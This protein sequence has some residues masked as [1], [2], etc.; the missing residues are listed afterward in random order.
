ML[1]GR[2]WSR[3]RGGSV[4]YRFMKEGFSRFCSRCLAVRLSAALDKVFPWN[5]W[6]HLDVL[7]C[8]VLINTNH[9]QRH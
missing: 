3:W 2:R 4:S 5:I 8:S 1:I 6:P 9:I 7:P